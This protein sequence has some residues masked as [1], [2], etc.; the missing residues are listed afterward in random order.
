MAGYK[1]IKRLEVIIHLLEHYPNI[2]KMT[3]INRLEKD[4]DIA[5]TSRTTERDF[6][7]LATEFGIELLYNKAENG[8]RIDSSDQERIQSFFKF[9]E[10]VHLGELFKESL[11][12]FDLLRETVALEDSSKFK[13]IK[14][15]KPLLLAIKQ[16]KMVHF[17][18]ENYSKNTYKD[19]EISPL[20]I[21]EYLNR[22]YV[23]GVPKGGSHIRTF[24]L[25]RMNGLKIT[26]VAVINTKDFEP[27]LDKFINVVGLN[28]DA[29]ENP[30]YIHLAVSRNQYK[31]LASLPLHHSQEKLKE[32][33]GNRI[34]IRFYLIPNY[35][36]KM[37]ILKM[38]PEI[39]VLK[40]TW[41]R[42]EIKTMLQESLKQYT[43]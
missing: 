41:L 6:N 19:Y 10:L 20:Q 29:V 25:D 42:N 26:E 17:V 34:E 12:D 2:S 5:T 23:V 9:V 13:N 35:E 32:T 37:Q 38:G 39:E 8:Y 27:Q 3:L 18:H 28:Y 31:Y 21:R 33:T 16:Q 7:A 4:Y 43:R 14:L 36:L 1:L 22:W 40:P 15:I 24:G 30:E 11:Q